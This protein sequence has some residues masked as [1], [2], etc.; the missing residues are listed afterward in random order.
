MGCGASSESPTATGANTPTAGDSPT[1]GDPSKPQHLNTSGP[2]KG[3]SNRS[4]DRPI[5][6]TVTMITVKVELGTVTAMGTFQGKPVGH[7]YVADSE[8]AE[9]LHRQIRKEIV[10]TRRATQLLD[11]NPK[12]TL[13]QNKVKHGHSVCIIFD[14][15]D[16]NNEAYDDSGGYDQNAM[17][18]DVPTFG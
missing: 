6:G 3:D 8:T 16:P 7:L 12:K 18:V 2:T 17:M 11:L 5:S 4:I 15:E 10:K 9:S 1:N 13:K 14:D